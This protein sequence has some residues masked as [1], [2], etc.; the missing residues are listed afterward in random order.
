LGDGV[1]PIV[2]GNYISRVPREVMRL[3][4]GGADHRALLEI[5]TSLAFGRRTVVK[6][7]E[8]PSL[9]EDRWACLALINLDRVRFRAV[10]GVPRLDDLV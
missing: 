2:Y 6:N 5:F 3:R 1:D 4:K 8:P 7:P 9:S 10:K